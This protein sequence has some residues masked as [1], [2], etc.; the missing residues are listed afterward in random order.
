MQFFLLAIIPFGI[1]KIWRCFKQ[2]RLLGIP[3]RRAGRLAFDPLM[4]LRLKRSRL[5]LLMP[6]TL[7]AGLV[8]VDVG[9]NA[10]S[11]SEDL[12]CLVSLGQLLVIEPDP[13]LQAGLEK[14]LGR[15]RGVEIVPVAVGERS[16]T[17]PFNQMENSAMNSFLP[18]TS[19]TVSSYGP[20]AVAQ[21]VVEVPVK[22]L[23]IL[24]AALPK[25]DLLK[26]DVQG[27]ER[28]VLRGATNTLQRT[29]HVLLEVN[30]ISH[31]DG[32]MSF[33]ELDEAM[34]Q[35][36]FALFNL[37]SPC[38]GNDGRVLWADALYGRYSADP[39]GAAASVS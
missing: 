10:G 1:V 27:Y 36:G 13:R 14:K 15:H 34:R 25:I 35:A 17:L 28:E 7:N 16:G 20:T 33:A 3:L 9:A 5:D 12:L 26:I 38:R 19:E 24:T 22:S 39:N 2:L 4:P 18:P 11:W 23:D 32:E 8:A 21:S 37:S 29:T 6:G 31:Y 30:Y